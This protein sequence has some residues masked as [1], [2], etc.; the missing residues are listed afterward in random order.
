MLAYAKF[1]IPIALIGFVRRGGGRHV[2]LQHGRSGRK[3]GD[4]LAS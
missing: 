3:N 2:L 4:R 1:V